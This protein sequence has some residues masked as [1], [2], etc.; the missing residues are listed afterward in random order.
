MGEKFNQDFHTR[1]CE[2]ERKGQ[3]QKMREE[4]EGREREIVGK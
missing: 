1:G 2:G 3:R 4:K